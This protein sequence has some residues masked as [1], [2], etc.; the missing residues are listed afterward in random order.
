MKT[1]KCKVIDRDYHNIITG[2]KTIITTTKSKSS[3]NG[4]S[5]D[6]INYSSG[7]ILGRKRKEMDDSKIVG[8]WH[9]VLE[10]ISTGKL[11]SLKTSEDIP[12]KSWDLVSVGVRKVQSGKEEIVAFSFKG[13]DSDGEKSKIISVHNENFEKFSFLNY[14]YYI[15]TAFLYLIP[16]AVTYLNFQIVFKGLWREEFKGYPINLVVVKF[17]L[18]IF[19]VMPLYKIFKPLMSGRLNF[20]VAYYSS[21]FWGGL[22][23]AL[24]LGGKIYLDFK[25]QKELDEVESQ[26]E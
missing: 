8:M 12:K 18:I 13:L 10:E 17:I 1:H 2:D 11:L 15:F 14:K 25:H 9:Y 26:R 22:S 6:D 24:L 3:N 7:R 19:A 4:N 20:E 16:F 5:D 21:L 23:V